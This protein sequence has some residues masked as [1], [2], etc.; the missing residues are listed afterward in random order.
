[1]GADLYIQ[2]ISDMQ[3]DQF[4]PAFDGFVKV[5]DQLKSETSPEVLIPLLDEVVA[6]L[7]EA[8]DVDYAER[9]RAIASDLAQAITAH[10]DEPPVPVD[11]WFHDEPVLTPRR[12]GL[13]QQGVLLA[14]EAMFSK[15]YFRDS[16]NPGSVAW[17]MGLSWWADVSEKLTDEEA[18]MSPAN[19]AIL[20]DMVASREIDPEHV[21]TKALGENPKEGE[22]EEVMAYFQVR[23]EKLIAFL[24]EA[25]EKGEPIL[26]SL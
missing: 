19:A 5:R 17:A 4:Q 26:A 1:M 3:R 20:R 18:M 21:R 14:H 13:A 11:D 22:F 23:R 12:E 10:T 25:I 9:L 2:S 6:K 15:G 8:E 16:Y 24:T 7:D